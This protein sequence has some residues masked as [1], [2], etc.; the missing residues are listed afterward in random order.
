MNWGAFF[1]I[2]I[3]LTTALMLIQRTEAKRRRLA[4]ILMIFVTFLTYYWA[5]FRT[6]SREFVLAFAAGLLINGL[7]W[8]LIGRYNPVGDSDDSIQVIGMDD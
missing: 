5:S 4:I 3:I 2:G 7:F 1:V 6:L 8:L